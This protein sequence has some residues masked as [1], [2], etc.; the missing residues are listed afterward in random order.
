MKP[1]RIALTP[2]RDALV[3]S[4]DDGRSGRIPA[5]RLR[6]ESRAAG[7][8]RAEIDGTAAPA[9]RDLTIVD[10]QLVGSYAITVFFA[11]G[12]DRAIYPWSMLRRL[13][14][15]EMSPAGN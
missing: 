10:V 4:W 1:T 12:H 7:A 2:E 8:L 15:G 11:D 14:A 9:P 5:W 13:A 3:V 6:A